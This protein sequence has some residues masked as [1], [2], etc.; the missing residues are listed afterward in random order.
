MEDAQH[1]QVNAQE[2]AIL[3]RFSASMAVVFSP[4]WRKLVVNLHW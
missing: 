2:V 1:R 3:V 4:H